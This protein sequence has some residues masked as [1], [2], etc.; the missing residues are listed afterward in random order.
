MWPIL[1]RKDS[2]LYIHYIQHNQIKK[3]DSVDK[4]QK[5]KEKRSS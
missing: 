4:F 3:H 5:I 2:I 1:T